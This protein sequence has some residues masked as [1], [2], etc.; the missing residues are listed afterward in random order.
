V[1]VRWRS[2]TMNGPPFCLP[3]LSLRDLRDLRGLRI[4]VIFVVSLLAGNW[5]LEVDRVCYGAG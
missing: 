4:F 3:G 2:K 5:R 1:A